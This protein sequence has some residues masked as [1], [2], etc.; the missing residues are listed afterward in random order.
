MNGRIWLLNSAGLACGAYGMYRYS[1]ATWADVAEDMRVNRDRVVSRIGYVQTA[2]LIERK[3]GFRPAIS[4]ENS[5][6]A[7]GDYA[8]VVRLPYRV[9]PTTKGTAVL[10]ADDE[11][12]VA[13][14]ERLS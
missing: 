4:R 8:Y 11:W 12:E 2:A 14:L 9:D 5:I 3:T 10:I 13:L 7:E 6:L 1:E